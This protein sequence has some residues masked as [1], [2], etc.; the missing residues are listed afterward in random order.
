[1]DRKIW[2]VV[3]CMVGLMLVAFGQKSATKA[4]PTN[5]SRYQM[6]NAQQE[7]EGKVVFVLDTQSGSVWKYQ[8]A[9]APATNHPAIPEAFI[10][11]G[12]GEPKIGA[13]DYGLK[14]S[15]SED[16]QR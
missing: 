14:W 4:E 13:P 3:V 11:V 5:A 15:A 10:P 8:A 16:S 2:L 6:T 7:Q 12:F 9:L 1:M